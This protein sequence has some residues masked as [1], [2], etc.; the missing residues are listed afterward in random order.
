M[1]SASP[2]P[3]VEVPKTAVGRTYGY[4]RISTNPEVESPEAQAEIMAAYC[5]GIG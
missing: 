2:C 5:R 3:K 1:T 4:L